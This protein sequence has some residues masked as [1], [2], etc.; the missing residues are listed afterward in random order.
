M[1]DPTPTATGLYT[2]R[3]PAKVYPPCVLIG[4]PDITAVTLDHVQAAIP[5]HLVAAGPGK[6]AGDQ[7]LYHV[8]TV[9]GAVGETAATPTVLNIDS[10]EY[11]AYLITARVNITS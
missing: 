2:T 11:H 9:L 4:L 10:G 6:P 1:T 8:I 5:V 3:D 7:L